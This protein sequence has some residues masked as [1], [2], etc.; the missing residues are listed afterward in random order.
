MRDTAYFSTAA[1]VLPVLFILLAVEFRVFGGGARGTWWASAG[2]LKPGEKLPLLGSL[3]V[4]AACFGFAMAEI[5]ALSAVL[6]GKPTQL[7]EDFVEATTTLLVV[8]VVFVP[9]Q[10]HV[11]A[12]LDRTPLY[13]FKVWWWRRTGVLQ[14]DDPDL[15][16][17]YEYGSFPA[18]IIRGPEPKA[19][20]PTEGQP[21][22]GQVPD[23][24]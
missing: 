4:V 12:L 3:F 10:P 2:E 19:D 7:Q 14:P 21:K 20:S 22:Q 15:P 24:A 8:M 9:A 1:Q 18:P 23:D 13:R 6:S 5:T 11:E 17:A 16:K